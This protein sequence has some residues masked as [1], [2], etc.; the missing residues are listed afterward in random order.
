MGGQQ[1]QQ[2]NQ[3]QRH[4]TLSQTR[5]DQQLNNQ[6]QMGNNMQQQYQQPNLANQ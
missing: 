2:P 5:F 6:Q 1:Q 3:Y 4:Q